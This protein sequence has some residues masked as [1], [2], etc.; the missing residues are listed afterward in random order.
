[1]AS[2]ATALGST[3]VNVRDDN[4][5]AAAAGYYDEQG[6]YCS[7]GDRGATTLTSSAYVDHQDEAR[8]RRQQH[9]SRHGAAHLS[10]GGGAGGGPSKKE[11]QVWLKL[12]HLFFLTGQLQKRLDGQAFDFDSSALPSQPLPPAAPKLTIVERRELRRGQ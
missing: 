1:M 5:G 2:A 11:T 12:E 7:P 4:G 3:E 9:G 8:R 10:L 6:V